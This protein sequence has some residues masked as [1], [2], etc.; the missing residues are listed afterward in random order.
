MLPFQRQL[1][2]GSMELMEIA[3]QLLMAVVTSVWMWAFRVS[4]LLTTQQTAGAAFALV[5][6]STI[7][8]LTEKYLMDGCACLY[9]LI[10]YA[11]AAVTGGAMYCILAIMVDG[12]EEAIREGLHFVAAAATATS[13]SLWCIAVAV[14][15]L[16]V[17]ASG[18]RLTVA[19]RLLCVPASGKRLTAA[20]APRSSQA[21]A[22]GA[23]L[24]RFTSHASSAGVAA[25]PRTTQRPMLLVPDRTSF[26][27][28]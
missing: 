11:N 13:L 16:C 18:K 9:N 6:L 2:N 25:K 28:V 17:P 23:S 20:T 4:V 8:Y 26:E 19:V 27:C 3:A 21:R 22:C 12:D 5:L 10:L 15:L 1:D 24:Y 7:F 14:R